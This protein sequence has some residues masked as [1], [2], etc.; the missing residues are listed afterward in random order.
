LIPFRKDRIG[1]RGGGICVYVSSIFQRSQLLHSSLD[2]CDYESLWVRIPDYKILI[3]AAY[4]PPNLNKET[5]NDIEKDISNEAECYLD[6]F[7]H[8]YLIMAG[9]F[10]QFRTD[11]LQDSFDLR[12]LVCKATRGESI[13]DK[14]LVDANIADSYCEAIIGPNLGKSDHH[15]VLIKPLK[16]IPSTLKYKKLF[17]F[18]KSNLERCKRILLNFPWQTFYRSLASIDEKCDLFHDMINEAMLTIPCELVPITKND[19]PWIT[20]LIKSLINKR[21][22]A[23]RS[24]NFPLYEHYKGKV[25]KEIFKAKQ[26]WITSNTKS[27]KKFWNIINN[28]RNKKCVNHLSS[29]LDSYESLESAANEINNALASHFNSM[30]SL[31]V[32]E[33]G[34]NPEVW[35]VEVTVL[36]VLSFLKKLKLSKSSGSDNL[37][38]RLLTFIAD[39][40]AGPLTHII[41]LS[42]NECYV[43]I[44]WKLA[45]ICPVPKKP[46]PAINDLRPLSMLPV[47]SKILESVVLTSVKPHLLSLYGEHQFGFRPLSSTLHAHISLHNFITETLDLKSTDAMI[48]VSTDLKRAFDSV[49]HSSLLKTLER[50]LFPLPFIK[51][52]KSYL[53]DRLQRVILESSVISRPTRVTSGVPQGSILAP[54]LFAAHMGTLQPFNSAAAIFKYADDVVTAIP[55]VRAANID[56]LIRDELSHIGAWCCDNGLTLNA[57]KTK[58]LVIPKRGTSV[59]QTDNINRE[60]VCNELKI[61]GVIYNSNLNWSSHVMMICKK[62]RRNLY[63]LRQLKRLMTKENLH[64]VYS[65]LIMSIL[66]YCAPLFIGLDAQNS[67]R[68]EKVRKQCHRIICGIHCECSLFENIS[69]RRLRQALRFFQNMKSPCSALHHL[70]PKTL[71]SSGKLAMPFCRTQR[72]LN[73]FLPQ[74]IILYNNQANI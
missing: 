32:D 7:P 20:P 9:D 35:N 5:L 50:G 52:C 44:R 19:K 43:P 31:I 41:C 39:A 30:E 45:N 1:K 29:L 38:P 66:E 42:I 65:S 53:Q 61:L 22:S 74:C 70:F 54:Y 60:F 28:T 17:D 27:S 34:N 51:W 56:L 63:V 4:I 12:Q 8:H 14:V 11:V 71:P 64:N 23:F 16:E 37:P 40:I 68:I 69:N 59:N 73:S 24:R 57:N 3:F 36:V 2:E 62:A 13:L 15:S 10:N 49:A 33:S 26:K 6:S 72:R 58:V 67:K 47:F 18:R 25:R 21:Y 48:L 46:R 55:I